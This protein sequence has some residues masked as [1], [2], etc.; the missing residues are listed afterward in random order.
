MILPREDMPHL[1]DGTPLDIVLNPIGVPS[2]MNLGQLLE[3]HLGWAARELDFAAITPVFDSASEIDIEDELAR[4]WFVGASGA[5]NHRDL[6]DREIRRE[7][8]R[9]WL[10]SRGY[11]YA[12]LHGHSPED[13]G[14]ASET[15]MRIWLSEFARAEDVSGLERADLLEMCRKLDR[16][17]GNAAPILGKQTLFDGRTGERFDQPVTVGS[18][19]MMKLIHWQKTKCTHVRPDH[20]P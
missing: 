13:I 14:K 12:E 2:R 9:S 10:E 18:I 4:A 6:T 20:T 19:Y 3:T 5:R 15:C 7:H 11:D 1:Q 17:V 16:E 8:V